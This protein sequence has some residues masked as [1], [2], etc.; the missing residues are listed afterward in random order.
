MPIGSEVSTPKKDK[1]ALL[2][3]TARRIVAD[4][5]FQDL[6]MATVA[7]AAGMAVGTIY[8]YFPSK[9]QLCVELVSMASQREV[10][11]L[12]GIALSEGSPEQKLEEVIRAFVGRAMQAPRYA[13]A[14]NVEPVFPEVELARH[15]YDRKNCEVLESILLEGIRDGAFRAMDVEI[16]AACIFGAFHEG[17][18]GP[19]A[20]E[21]TALPDHVPDLIDSMVEFCLASVLKPDRS[22]IPH[23]APRPAPNVEVLKTNPS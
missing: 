19:L 13:Y 21:A 3:A 12:A 6:Q 1:K 22:Q 5:G 10:D 17:L 4:G 20:P 15:T 2:L 7:N 11:V 18:V 9:M 14:M 23:T 8:R 16:S